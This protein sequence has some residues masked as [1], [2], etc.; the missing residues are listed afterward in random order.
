[1]T[2]IIYLVFAS[3]EYALSQLSGCKQFV[4]T[5]KGNRRKLFL[6]CKGFWTRLL[7]MILLQ[8]LPAPWCLATLCWGLGN[9]KTF[10]RQPR[11]VGDRYKTLL[12]SA[13]LFPECCRK[14]DQNWNAKAIPS[15]TSESG[16]DG[17][18]FC[19]RIP[20]PKLAR[21]LAPQ[22]HD[23]ASSQSTWALRATSSMRLWL[24][25]WPACFMRMQAYK[26][27]ESIKL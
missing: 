18:Q 8:A 21:K 14:L 13:D 9:A 3:C 12:E 26:A 25:H 5:S 4:W 6:C 24:E 16:S 20:A 15:K 27:Q 10:M 17:Y 2:S 11:Q 22:I 23:V 1:M 7:P 19:C